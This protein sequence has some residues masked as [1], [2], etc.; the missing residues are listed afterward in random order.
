MLVIPQSEEHDS[1]PKSL[2]LGI[3]LSSSLHCPTLEELTLW[4]YLSNITSPIQSPLTQSIG[5]CPPGHDMPALTTPPEPS[6]RYP[7]AP[8]P[9]EIIQTSQSWAC[10]FV[11]PVSSRIK[12]LA[13]ASRPTWCLVLSCVSS[14]GV[15]CLLFPGRV[16]S[17]YY[18]IWPALSWPAGLTISHISINVLNLKSRLHHNLLIKGAEEIQRWIEESYHSLCETNW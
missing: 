2:F 14:C 12:T 13:A 10:I 8:E 3:L 18:F 11:L 16:T 6:I 4:D 9:T 15:P 7:F 5:I 1:L 17:Y